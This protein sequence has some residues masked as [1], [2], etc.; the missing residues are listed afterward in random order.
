MET[1]TQHNTTQHNTKTTTKKADTKHEIEIKGRLKKDIE[2]ERLICIRNEQ[3]Q[4]Q[5]QK[6]MTWA[7]MYDQTTDRPTEWKH[8]RVLN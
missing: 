8:V 5:Q 1:T 4:Q 6:D 2:A 3:Q 7:W